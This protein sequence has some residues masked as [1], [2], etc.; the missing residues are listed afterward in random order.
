ML[1]FHYGFSSNVEVSGDEGPTTSVLGVNVRT[2]LPV[3]K[4]LL[5]GPMLEFGAYEP[6]YYLDLDVT[7]RARIPIEAGDTQFQFWVGMPIGL[8]FSF[9]TDDFSRTYTPDLEPFSLGWNIGVLAGGA[10]H[11]SREFGLFGEF[12][13]QEHTMSHARAETG[14]V[15]LVLAPWIMNVGFVFRG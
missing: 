5:I 9:L 10:V 12:G 6:A 7:L 1:A 13:W 15:E 4:Y 8:T 2:D 3:A 11:F 14:S